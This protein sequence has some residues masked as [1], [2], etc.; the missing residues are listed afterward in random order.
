[1]IN[2][3]KEAYETDFQNGLRKLKQE[4]ISANPAQDQSISF[5]DELRGNAE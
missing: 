5:H 2:Q 3:I 4:E 1:V